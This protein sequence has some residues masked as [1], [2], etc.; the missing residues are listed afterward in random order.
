VA[1][2]SIRLFKAINQHIREDG[3]L[4][5]AT[6]Q[7]RPITKQHAEAAATTAGQSRKIVLLL[8]LV[9]LVSGKMALS[10]LEMLWRG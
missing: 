7:S 4:R 5:E 8:M 1:W 10:V 9:P 3:L 2:R 6:S